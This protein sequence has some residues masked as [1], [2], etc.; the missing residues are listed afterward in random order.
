MKDIGD[1]YRALITPF[2]KPKRPTVAFVSSVTGEPLSEAHDFSAEYWQQNLENPVL[3]RQAVSKLLQ[4]GPST[5]SVHIEVGPHSALAGPL[6]Q[7]Y[8]EHRLQVPYTSVLKRASSDSRALLA[9]VGHLHCLGIKVRLPVPDDDSSA[10]RPLTDLPPYPWD[11]S[12][13]YWTQSRS[14]WEWQSPRAP[15]HE[16]LGQRVR[17][18]SDSC[19]QWRC[20]LSLESVPWIADHRVRGQAMFPAAAYIAMAGEV[21]QQLGGAG[22]DKRSGFVLRDLHI[23]TALVIRPGQAVEL[24]TEARHET[25]SEPERSAW[26][27][28]SIMS[29]QP[30]GG[31]DTDSN[32]TWVKHCTCRARAA[33]SQ[34]AIWNQTTNESL[35]GVEDTC[36]RQV[37][38]ATWYKAMARVGYNYGPRFRGIRE[39][40]TSAKSQAACVRVAVDEETIQNASS[41][42]AVHPTAMDQILQA[43]IMAGHGGETYLL[44]KMWLPVRIDE[45]FVGHEHGEKFKIDVKASSRGFGNAVCRPDLHG[46]GHA[47]SD[48]ISSFKGIRLAPVDSLQNAE[49]GGAIEL[50]WKPDIDLVDPAS[51]VQRT[52]A[53]DT[54]KIQSLLQE[55]FILCALDLRKTLP[56][57]TGL[58]LGSSAAESSPHLLNQYNWVMTLGLGDGTAA[59]PGRAQI[60]S[61]IDSLAKQLE[62]TPAAAAAG[63]ISQCHTHARELFSGD[64]GPLD[65]FLQDN[66]LHRLY[67]WMNSLW[68]YRRLLQLLSHQRGRT[69]KILE[70]GAGTGGLTAR[71][72]QDLKEEED[73]TE[74]YS[75]FGKYVFTDVSAGFFPA[76]KERFAAMVPPQQMEYRVLDI[77][78]PPQDQGFGTGEYDLIIASNVLHATLDLTRTLRHVRSL[79]RPDGRLLLQELAC[80]AGSKWINFIMGFLPGWWL[81]HADGRAA[82]PYLAPEAWRGRLVDAGFDGAE[83][84]AT[85]CDMPLQ[86]NATMVARPS[87]ITR[88]NGAEVEIDPMDSC[89]GITLL[90]PPE[91]KDGVDGRR[92]AVQILEERLLSR[93]YSVSRQSISQFIFEPHNPTR[94]RHFIVSA[95]DLCLHDGWFHSLTEQKLTSFQRLVV[96]LQDHNASMLWLTQPCQIGPR[97]PTFSQCLGV[98]RTVRAELGLRFATLEVDLVDDDGSD[99]NAAT[100]LE[101]ISRA[102]HAFA[103]KE[104]TAD[105]HADLRTVDQD[106]EMAYSSETKA[107]VIPRARP[108]SI[109]S[110]ISHS[111]IRDGD[112]ITA[113][114]AARPGSLGSLE[115]TTVPRARS[116]LPSTTPEL[117]PGAVRIRIDAAGLNFKDVM[118]AM[119]LIGVPGSEDS[120]G[121]DLPLGCEAAGVITAVGSEVSSL[122]PIEVGDRVTIFAPQAGCFSTEVQVDARLCTRIPDT[123]PASEAAGMPCI[124]TT[125]LR[126]L[127]KAGGLEPGHTILI[128]S[129]TGGVGL[130]A[131]Q[132]TRH[133]G[134]PLANV[135][136][137]AGSG[138]KRAFLA[139]RCG[140]LPGHVFSSRDDSFVDGLMAVTG[141]R[142]VDVV[143]NSLSGDL[144]HAS[145]ECVA[146]GGTL[147]ELGKRDVLAR[148]RLA[149]A[150]FDDNRS[151][152]AVD[153]ARLAVQDPSVVGRLLDRT[154]DLYRQGAITPV[155]PLRVFNCGEVEEAFRQLSKQSHIGKV[156]VDMRDFAAVS[157]TAKKGDTSPSTSLPLPAPVLDP[158]AV[159]ILVGGLG[160]L[161]TSISR[162]LASHGATSLAILSRSGAEGEG[163]R[164]V[165]AG[166]LE[167][168]CQVT[169]LSC[170]VT[171]EHAVREALSSVSATTQKRIAGVLFLP[172]VLADAAIS[173]MTIDK[174]RAATDPKVRGLWNVHNA[175]PQPSRLDFFVLFG[176]TSGLCGYPGQSNYAAANSFLDSFA[177]YR[178]GLGLPCSVVDLGPV[179]DVGHVSNAEDIQATMTR[180]SARFVSERQMLQAVQLAMLRSAVPPAHESRLTIDRGCLVQGQVGVG[181]DV[182][183]PLEDARN[184]VVWK[185]DPRMVTLRPGASG[186]RGAISEPGSGSDGLTDFI[187]RLR[188]DPAGLDSPST[189]ASIACAIASRVFSLLSRELDQTDEAFLASV[190]LAS[191]GI[192]SLVT[193]EVR[194]WWRRTFG[195][196][197]SSMQLMNAGNF[198]DL[199]TLAITQLKE[200]Y[201][202]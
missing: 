110:A 139:E 166:L 151:F 189:L 87:I 75:A 114:R 118:V 188:S 165:L 64:V 197:V 25:G 26:W 21:V 12:R 103:Q 38:P 82:E 9:A 45:V 67:D 105:R 60:G 53:N 152:V 57:R 141:G 33:D 19:P 146:A 52:S 126:G 6:K 190:S 69:L 32:G 109:H 68:S 78:Q 31:E 63:L 107:I 177:Q 80:G 199:A 182:E 28:L 181:F 193:I 127:D 65:L 46:D 134:V 132:V 92:G 4:G 8:N 34:K 15:S 195:F 102:I 147:V 81:G 101:H 39:I 121:H 183:I 174:W 56:P 124:F 43:M 161:G 47:A 44:E 136:A 115:W 7:I 157:P 90:V 159:Y 191:L 71:V 23:Q 14:L 133:L 50:V 1:E 180:S 158:E 140:L 120:Q 198:L 96:Q 29:F 155:Q 84:V 108:V 196:Q 162:W 186:S 130:A 40:G 20:V 3:F 83:V 86:L 131:L 119:G 125:V 17:H 144:L 176:S 149:M 167:M 164:K 18:V 85:D 59:D 113:L 184:S 116:G 95:V 54:K 117:P 178:R 2:L 72:L 89:T 148:A 74:E 185:R 202:K 168:G 153:M 179:E 88:E 160:G 66:A 129:A 169:A 201:R 36:L 93:G 22:G 104:R 62:N 55:M 187:S 41:R 137:T 150:P 170:D 194:N 5:T 27:E 70:I 143:L 48:P 156:V 123:L 98:A 175:L 24:I 138:E 154:L 122:R 10:A 106:T 128:H 200:A 51:L 76:A 30:G 91:F 73:T 97:N 61:R 100:K 112:T 172:M 163:S 16:L 173:D 99:D 94:Q 142:G 77:S 171:D 58:G 13:T 111:T 145:W 11:L 135:Y 35:A 49:Q 79:L 192:D 42:Y 37:D